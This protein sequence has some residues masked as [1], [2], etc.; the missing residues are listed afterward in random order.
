MSEEKIYNTVTTLD[1]LMYGNMS[2][3]IFKENKILVNALKDIKEEVARAKRK[4]QKEVRRHSDEKKRL[5]IEI[6]RLKN[7]IKK[8]EEK[9]SNL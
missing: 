9:N 5:Q 2:A 8:Y 6:L 3:K 1:I 4:R 7:I